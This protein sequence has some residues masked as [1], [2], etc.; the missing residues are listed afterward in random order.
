VADVNEI[1]ELKRCLKG[2]EKSCMMKK[3]K[4]KIKKKS[5]IEGKRP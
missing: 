1:E 3:K 2:I 4:Q 5:R